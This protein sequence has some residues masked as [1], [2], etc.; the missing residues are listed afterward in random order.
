MER[1]ITLD[2][3]KN[4]AAELALGNYE[5]VG[6]VVREKATGKIVTWLRET[7]PTAGYQT[8]LQALPGMEL[9]SMAGN[10]A[11]II[12]LGATVAFGVS[13]LKG[14]RRVEDKLGQ[15]DHKL[16]IMDAKLEELSA[17]ADNIQ[18][19]VDIGFAHTSQALDLIGRHQE[20]ELMG[21]LNSA[22]NM[23]WSCQFLEPG[24]HQRLN[25]IENAFTTASNAKEKVLLHAKSEM[26]NAI[27]KVVA[28]RQSTPS[29]DFSED[30]RNSVLRV[31]QAIMAST[32]N[33]SIAAEADDLFTASAQ[34]SREHAT[35]DSL[36]TEMLSIAFTDNEQ[37]LQ[38]LYRPQLSEQFS[39]RDL[40]TLVLRYNKQHST[41]HEIVDSLRSTGIP[42]DGKAARQHST[43]EPTERKGPLIPNWRDLSAAQVLEAMQKIKSSPSSDTDNEIA[44]LQL[45]E[46]VSEELDRMKGY[47]LEYQAGQSLVSSMQEYRELTSVDEIP[48]QAGIYFITPAANAA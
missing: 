45:A 1:T 36:V 46:G 20:I 33:A 4:V 8:P 10:A 7:H 17:R 27:E 32:L 15:M 43:S 42:S 14:I 6:G 40:E 26:E 18:W 28:A 2:I 39:T 3:P 31:R 23:A 11:S 47:G 16:D 35:L 9:L 48:D 30:V 34:I 37:V 12:N 5:R 44:F 41:A 22:A 29:F 21:E 13:T 24:S 25:R 19:A 38:Y